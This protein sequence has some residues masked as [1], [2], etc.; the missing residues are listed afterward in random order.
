MNNLP[1]PGLFL[2]YAFQ[3]HPILPLSVW[4][5]PIPTSRKVK[6]AI[7]V[8]AVSDKDVVL[9]LVELDLVRKV[10]FGREHG[11]STSSLTNDDHDEAD[12]VQQAPG[13]A[14]GEEIELNQELRNTCGCRCRVFWAVVQQE[15][16]KVG[17]GEFL[18]VEWG[19]VSKNSE[20]WFLIQRF[21]PVWVMKQN[22]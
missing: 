6:V 11:Q 8:D 19:R 4:T 18:S 3:A 2:H 7:P 12:F 10:G 9:L 13:L 16:Y 15:C 20:F 17:D 22:K 21:A 14:L 1:N 5:F